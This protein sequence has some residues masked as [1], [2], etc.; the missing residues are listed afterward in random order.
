MK[1][2]IKI[3]LAYLLLFI[4]ILLI[5]ST[6]WFTATFDQLSLDE[7][8][9]HLKVPLKGSN[10]DFLVSY[11]KSPLRK[12]VVLFFLIIV[13][14]FFVK[15]IYNHY[16]FS[17]KNE[18]K[19]IYIPLILLLLF[20]TNYSVQSLGVPEYLKNILSDSSLYNDEY[21][22]AS[23]DLITFPKEKRNLIY[24]FVES[25]ESAFASKELGGALD[26]NT[27][28]KISDLANEEIHFSNTDRIGGATTPTGTTWTVGGMVAQTSGINLKLP[29]NSNTYGE[30]EY[31][32]PGVVSLG[33][34]LE[35]E[36]YNQTLFIGSDGHF[37][38]RSNYF[39]QHG[40]YEIKDYN[41]AIKNDLIPKD[42][43]EWWGFEDEKL[44]EFAKDDLLNLS[45]E[46][47]PFNFTMLTADTHHIGGYVTEGMEM[48][49]EDQYK[50]V[51]YNSSKQL[52]E[53]ITWIQA[54]DF[55][56]NTTIV[57][58]G[59]HNTMDAEF[60]ETFVSPEYD[61]RTFNLIINSAI[62]PINKEYREFATFDLF[63]TTLASMGVEIEGERL[64]LGTNL[65]SDKKT[66]V[67]EYG[68]DYI[69]DELAKHSTYYAKNILEKKD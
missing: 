14:L 48:P 23:S 21:V 20:S 54:Q 1:H 19:L 65:F 4:S 63:P 24:I 33:Q 57:I 67:E 62:E 49:F 27:L 52:Y 66:I 51:I 37:G 7:I 32:L 2:Y 34:L 31:F 11:I 55:Y 56:E 40:N 28:Y 12:S 30:Y 61:R 35:A 22:E 59:D 44:F 10:S 42:Y 69:N 58:S 68:F 9:F 3:L 47:K 53:F 64:G 6:N 13:I 5:Y 41:Y 50:N 60:V 46:D 45:S 25:Y 18:K 26:E 39:T 43:L 29:I 16:Q 8:I 17:L 15:K 38:G 36:D